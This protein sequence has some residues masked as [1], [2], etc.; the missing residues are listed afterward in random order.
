MK[1][2]LFFTK[3]IH[4][5]AGRKLYL[6]LLSMT[7]VSIFEGIG[8]F[9]LIPLISLTGIIQ[10]STNNS[11]LLSFLSNIFN[12]FPQKVS[13]IIIL[14]SYV[15]LI[16]G[17]G[18]FQRSQMIMNVKIQQGYSLYLKEN[19]YKSLLHS[20][21]GFFVKKRKSD[22]I[23][24]I[25]VETGR[26]VGGVQMFLQFLS[27]LVF[28]SIQLILAFWLSPQLTISVLV[29]GALL[30]FFSRR[31]IYKSS[32]LGKETVEL[33]KQFFAGVTD[34]LNGIKEIKSNN[35][36]N[37]HIKWFNSTSR[38]LEENV[39]KLVK[40]RNFSQLISKIVSAVLL[41]SFIFLFLEM[42][43]VQAAQLML[44]M[45]I[46][47]RLWPRITGIQT[48]LEQLSSVLP[49]FKV[50]LDLQRE[51]TLAKELEEG[52]HRECKYLYFQE[53]IECRDISFRYSP[54][55]KN[56][57][58]KNVNLLI[59]A[60]QMTAIV[61]PSGAGKSTLIDILM[62]L[63]DPEQGDVFIDGLK[64]T[65]DNLFALRRSLSYVPQDPF[66]FNTTIR[67]NLLLIVQNASEEEI[68]KALEFAAAADF[69]R[70]FPAGLDT[71]IGDR[72]IKLSGGERQRLVL[73][74]AIL[75]NPSILILDEATSALDT[76]NESKI[77]EAIE[78]LKGKMTII[79]IAHRLSTIRN[80]D[81]V[82]V[83]DKGEIIQQGQFSQLANEKRGM[84]SRLLKKQMEVSV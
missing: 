73:A 31:F 4:Y 33:S 50:V 32:E 11:K 30:L 41:A 62:G 9:L 21:W 56:Y 20:N 26:V 48:N 3:Q 83:L 65:S 81:Q 71:L 69:V 1:Q 43:K 84:F 15:L 28:S 5:F 45:V 67:E 47:S 40:L 36:E 14:F 63:N 52:N 82:V 46:F 42:F 34:H 35:L 49:S 70:K 77:Q 64:L 44:I 66:L 68:W 23:N 55:D 74:R 24:M 16:T 61:G 22:L 27:S 57:A 53:G 8:I 6:N 54:S 72:G 2:L 38:E 25:T 76:E 10:V 58:L 13:L 19:T 79:V 29:C 37:P 39:I 12:A 75:R 18:L 60:N 78:K 17:Q 80:A 51:C 7:L 59:K